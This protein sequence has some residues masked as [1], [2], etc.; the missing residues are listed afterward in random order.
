MDIWAII[1]GIIGALGLGSFISRFFDITWFTNIL[2]K[3]ERGKWLF[4]RKYDAYL[5]LIKEI[6]A[7]GMGNNKNKNIIELQYL[8]AP[9]IMLTQNKTLIKEITDF[10]VSLKEFDDFFGSDES[11]KI[12][13][14]SKG[15]DI[16]MSGQPVQ[17]VT[18]EL[19]KLNKRSETLVELL[20]K[21][22]F[23]TIEK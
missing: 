13:K 16:V 5:D 22:L 4:E 15:N 14:D 12:A 9:A 1:L 23:S 10:I 11:Y 6:R 7:L 19:M 21:D 17:K 3:R 8:S 2:Q 18:I 20:K